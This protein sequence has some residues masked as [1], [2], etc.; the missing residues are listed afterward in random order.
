MKSPFGSPSNHGIT[1]IKLAK[2]RQNQIKT[3]TGSYV[4]LLNNWT[5]DASQIDALLHNLRILISTQES[6]QRM[7]SR[8]PQPFPIF[9]EM[10]SD[11]Y[12]L[13]T[14]KLYSEIE[15]IY[16]Q[17]KHYMYAAL[18]TLCLLTQWCYCIKNCNRKQS[19]TFR[20]INSCVRHSIGLGDVIVAM[21]MVEAESSS[22]L[23]NEVILYSVAH[24]CTFK[25][26]R[27]LPY[28]VFP[29]QVLIL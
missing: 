1:D 16:H 8:H 23:K 21:R 7:E 2:K 29:S 9:D 26:A 24:Y 4:K 10:F 5:Q 25:V 20:M 13:L 22:I 3:V 28:L 14:G 18:T 11:A 17:L 12:S 27:F 15:I 6:V 19:I